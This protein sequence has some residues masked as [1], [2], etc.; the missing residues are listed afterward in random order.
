METSFDAEGEVT[1][2]E[3]KN[4]VPPKPNVNGE[5]VALENATGEKIKLSVVQFVEED[6]ALKWFLRIMTVLLLVFLV[7]LWVYFR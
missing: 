6:P 7:F 4:A 1:K 5:T 2:I 3:E